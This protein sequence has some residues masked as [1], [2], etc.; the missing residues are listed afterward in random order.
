MK[1]WHT[2]NK[3]SFNS[4]KGLLNIRNKMGVICY[5]SNSDCGDAV[6]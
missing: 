3:K 4:R 1:F 5:T 2:K 6:K